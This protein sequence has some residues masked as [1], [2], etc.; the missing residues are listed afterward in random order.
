LPSRLDKLYFTVFGGA[1][2]APGVRLGVDDEA[3]ALWVAIGA[4]RKTA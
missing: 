3:L 2:V 4:P 1:E